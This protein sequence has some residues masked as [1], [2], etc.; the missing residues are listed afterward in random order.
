MRLYFESPSL[1]L[2]VLKLILKYN[3]MPLARHSAVV[4]FRIYSHIHTCSKHYSCCP[5]QDL[6]CPFKDG[7]KENGQH[8]E[9]IQH[10][11]ILRRVRLPLIIPCPSPGLIP[12]L[13]TVHIVPVHLGDIS[14]LGKR[15]QSQCRHICIS[16][17]LGG[18][19]SAEYFVSQVRLC[20][21]MNG[22]T[23]AVSTFLV[24]HTHLLLPSSSPVKPME[25][26]ASAG[27]V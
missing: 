6:K 8:D 26:Q 1:Y 13:C 15:L 11:Y 22:I 17:I 14:Y 27:R 2:T 21:C 16:H 24:P 20:T 9:Q 19:F 4:C 25:S 7:E 18:K 10:L 23:Y 3:L 12:P 5:P